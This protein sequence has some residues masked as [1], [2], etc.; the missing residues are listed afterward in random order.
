[1]NASFLGGV[2]CFLFTVFT[3][4]IREYIAALILKLFGAL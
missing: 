2:F 1:M 3:V 4:N